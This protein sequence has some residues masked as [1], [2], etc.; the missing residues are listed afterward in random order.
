MMLPILHGLEMR[1][2]TGMNCNVLRSEMYSVSRTSPYASFGGLDGRGGRGF[3]AGV[4]GRKRVSWR[5]ERIGRG[6]REK[7]GG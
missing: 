5:G 3:T 6:N 1:P 2:L 4:R 7:G